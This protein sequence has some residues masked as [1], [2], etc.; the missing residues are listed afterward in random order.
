[1]IENTSEMSKTKMCKSVEEGKKCL[2]GDNCRFAHNIDQLSIKEC[3]FKD[4]CTF[5]VCQET[6]TGVIYTNNE[7]KQKLCQ[8]LH[9][10]EILENYLARMNNKPAMPSLLRNVTQQQQQQQQNTSMQRPMSH[11]KATENGSWTRIVRKVVDHPSLNIVEL[12]EEYD[13]P[14]S[15]DAPTVRDAQQSNNEVVIRVTKCAV[16]TALRNMFRAGKSNI[17]I[18]IV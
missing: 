12:S 10:R 17:T 3:I 8:F 14:K 4:R 7:T 1:M 18:E 2:N 13:N 6:D 15:S 16:E 11:G 5:V 9:P